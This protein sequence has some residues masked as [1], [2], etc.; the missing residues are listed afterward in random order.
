M[1]APALRSTPDTQSPPRQ[2]FHPFQ[3]FTWVA[4]GGDKVG[5]RGAIGTRG[6]ASAAII[7]ARLF[8]GNSLLFVLGRG[9]GLRAHA[10]AGAY[11]KLELGRPD[12]KS[13]PLTCRRRVARRRHPEQHPVDKAGLRSGANRFCDTSRKT[14]IG[15]SRGR[16]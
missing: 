2:P 9:T 16:F 13:S 7:N 8:I 5:N 14:T 6:A 4:R 3:L 11:P 10:A 12:I 15:C 1:V